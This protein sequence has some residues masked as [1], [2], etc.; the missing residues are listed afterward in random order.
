MPHKSNCI[1]AVDDDRRALD[2]IAGILDTT[3]NVLT[4]SD[5]RRAVGWLHDD[6]TVCAIISEQVLRHGRGIDLLGASLKI[7]PDVRRILITNYGD[8]AAIVGCFHT[9]EIQRTISKPIVAA[10]LLG[11]VGPSQVSDPAGT[12]PQSAR[13]SATA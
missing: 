11:V 9:G 2:Q 13:A 4:T 6:A 12:A 7:R 5:L 3:Y 8:L 10:E 1:I